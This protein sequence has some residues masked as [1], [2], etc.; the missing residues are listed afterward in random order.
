[1]RVL[2]LPTSVGGNSW[3]LSQG[4]RR[5]GLESRV[6]NI[7]IN[8]L[9]Y[10]ADEIIYVPECSFLRKPIKF[11]KSLSA[12]LKNRNKY[13]IFH[14]NFGSSLLD[15]PKYGMY[16]LDLPF[17]SAKAKLFVTYNGCD[18]RQ[19]Y[20]TMQRTSIAACHNP[21]C[22]KGMCNSGEQDRIRRRKIAKLALYVD[23]MFAVNPDL[24]WFLPEA[25]ASFLPY[26]V[27]NW[28]EETDRPPLLTKKKLRVV[29]APTNRECKGSDIILKALYDL[30]TIFPGEIETILVEGKSYSE[31]LAIYRDADLIVDQVLVGW[32]GGL[33]VEV[34]RMGKPVAVYIREEDLRFIPPDMRKDLNDAFIRVQPD[35]INEVLGRF[36]ADRQALREK[37]ENAYH[38]VQKWHDPVK[39]ALQVKEYYE[40][41]R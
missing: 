35:T 2:H 39:I 40:G 14:F 17:Y 20:P 11:I 21:L 5:I 22:Y 15:Y 1:M 3:G 31:A 32:Y 19:K 12:F 9:A 34:M 16:A 28:F 13:D 25:K 26:T 29:H 8:Y 41:K 10:Q 37:A 4:E 33:A 23:H 18:A 36:V 7:G 30:E 27:A 38:Y 24:L 6:L